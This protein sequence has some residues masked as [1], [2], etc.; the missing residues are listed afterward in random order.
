M[1][2]SST[3]WK[4]VPPNPNALTPAVRGWSAP[5]TH[6]RASVLRYSGPPSRFAFGFGTSTSVGG[7]TLWCSA[8]AAL[9]S[10]AS[11][12]A[13]LLCPIIDFTEPIAHDCGRP[14]ASRNNWPIARA[15]VWS[16]TTVP[17]PCASTSPTRAGDRRAWAYARCSARN[18][19]SARGAVSPLSRPSLD[20]PTPLMTA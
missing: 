14:P 5:W 16:P 11:P 12:A 19:P 8:N 9:M 20:A 15:S 3:A 18:W 4:F 2:S 13:H 6:G 7:S 1:Y 10:P 17:V